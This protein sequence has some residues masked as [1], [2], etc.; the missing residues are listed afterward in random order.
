MRTT[1]EQLVEDILGNPE[2][3]D[4]QALLEA[5]AIAKDLGIYCFPAIEWAKEAQIN[6]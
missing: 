4:V 1:T 5:L 2:E 6:A 3:D